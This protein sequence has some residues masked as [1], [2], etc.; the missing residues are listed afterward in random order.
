MKLNYGFLEELSKEYNY[1]VP[2][3]KNVKYTQ[4]ELENI[5]KNKKEKYY[6]VLSVK[7]RKIRI[8][9]L[10]GDSFTEDEALL[11]DEIVYNLVNRDD[12][13]FDDENMK[14]DMEDNFLIKIEDVKLLEKEILDKINND[15]LN[16]DT[17]LTVNDEDYKF[18]FAMDELTILNIEEEIIFKSEN[19]EDLRDELFNFFENID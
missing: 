2:K 7:N 9:K 5:L 15:V 17:T 6:R 11:V 8:D 13:N 4:K 1:E 3:M 10:N 14:D 18:V 12:A 16:I 19:R